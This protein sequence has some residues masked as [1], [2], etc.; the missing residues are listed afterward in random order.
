MCN[1][2]TAVFIKM[3]YSNYAD[4]F[5]KLISG[6]SLRLILSAICCLIAPFML[7]KQDLI[8]SEYKSELT[9][10]DIFQYTSTLSNESVTRT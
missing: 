5:T 6:V 2:D 9:S 1:R 8:G 7:F 4:K 3:K 10:G